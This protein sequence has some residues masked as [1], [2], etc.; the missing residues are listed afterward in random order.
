[1]GDGQSPR[2]I[3]IT[4]SSGG[5]TLTR[6]PGAGAERGSALLITATGWCGSTRVPPASHDAS[7]M[8]ARCQPAAL[9][10]P[11]GLSY[12]WD[13]HGKKQALFP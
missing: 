10:L 7:E 3:L 11:I 6:T 13:K 12:F 9:S 2:G 5:G 1:M 4:A 8:P